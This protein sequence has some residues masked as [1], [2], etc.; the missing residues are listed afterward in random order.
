MPALIRVEKDLLAY[1]EGA[2]E[3]AVDL[4]KVY[5][6]NPGQ[7]PTVRNLLLAESIDLNLVAM[8][9]QAAVS[10]RAAYERQ[11]VR[12]I[13]PLAYELASPATPADPN[14]ERTQDGHHSHPRP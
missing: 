12:D 7:P 14:K 1:E 9:E 2:E 5:D 8:L 11:R 6:V 13:N 4:L 10:A 3:V